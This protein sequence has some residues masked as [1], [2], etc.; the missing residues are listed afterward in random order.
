MPDIS[1]FPSLQVSSFGPPRKKS[2]PDR[3]FPLLGW[4]EGPIEIKNFCVSFNFRLSSS[5]S[6]ID[7]NLGKRSE[8]RRGGVSLIF[9]SPQCPYATR[10][11]E[12]GEGWLISQGGRVPHT[13]L[14]TLLPCCCVY[15]KNRFPYQSKAKKRVPISPIART[16]V[17]TPVFPPILPL[18]IQFPTL[19]PLPHSFPDRGEWRKT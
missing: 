12:S 10:V 7:I 1:F 17:R 19:F 13:P 3:P 6:G 11:V 8:G 15:G 14:F 5:P 2:S 16:N 18:L 9:S 4:Q